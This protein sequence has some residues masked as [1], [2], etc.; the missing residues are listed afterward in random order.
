MTAG[1]DAAINGLWKKQRQTLARKTAEGDALANTYLEQIQC[2]IKTNSSDNLSKWKEDIKTRSGAAA[3]IKRR[4][5]L[6]TPTCLPTFGD[7]H[8]SFMSSA[9][10]FATQLS[11]RWNVGCH[12]IDL[13]SAN[14][15]SICQSPARVQT[16]KACPPPRVSHPLPG[17]FFDSIPDLPFHWDWTRESIFTYA[18]KGSC[19]LDGWHY[20]HF[21]AL[22]EL[23]LDCLVLLLNRADR[24]QFPKFWHD[25]KV[26]GIP[27]KGSIE[28]RPLT[29][30]SGTYRLW[31]RRQ[32][33][34]LGN[35]L[36]TWAPRSMFGGRVRIGASDAA[37]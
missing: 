5:A 1:N 13:E 10:H 35:W 2:L 14:L 18:S 4:L 20:D 31:A 9:Q 6:L 37:L 22:D 3:W 19:G 28:Y 23:S 16:F 8:L 17:N 24:G 11:Q 33:F 26:T 36:D 34:E 12:T 30:L 21:C 29:I 27:K 15:S 7:A 32:A 25:A